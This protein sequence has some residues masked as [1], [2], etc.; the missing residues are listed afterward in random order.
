MI[1]VVNKRSDG[2]IFHYAHFMCD[3]LFPE[4]VNDIYKYKEVVRKKNIN[5]TIGNFDKIYTEVMMIKNTELMET[6]FDNL[7]VEKL[8]YQNKSAYLDK[9]FFEKF[10]NFIFSR[11]EINPLEYDKQYPEVILIR[12]S[13]RVELISDEYLKK[14]NNNFKNGKER[15]EINNIERIEKY[16]ETKYSDNFKSLFFENLPF[17]EQVKYFNNARLIICAHG[18]VMANMFFCKE[19]ATIIEVTCN[20]NWDFFNKISK[21]VNLKHIKCNKNEYKNVIDCIESHPIQ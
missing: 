21:N 2:H 8:V 10:R 5:Q 7:N 20:T 17:K 18:A 3:C 16:L 1:K 15:R 9:Q 6:E 19:N 12:R 11:Y 13:T 4:I 14:I